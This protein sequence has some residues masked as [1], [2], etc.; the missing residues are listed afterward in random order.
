MGVWAKRRS[1]RRANQAPE[2]RLWRRRNRN[3]N[4]TMK[5]STDKV[6]IHKDMTLKPEDVVSL[7]GLVLTERHTHGYACRDATSG[8]RYD[9][10]GGA[11]RECEW[12]A[13]EQCK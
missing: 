5:R 8:R 12:V 6:C 4:R 13:G 1:R 9:D 11:A 2:V 3:P 7:R 10:D